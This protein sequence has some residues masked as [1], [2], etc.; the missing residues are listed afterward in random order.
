VAV[1]F[2]FT[3][4]FE[5][6]LLG[7]ADILLMPSLYEPCGITQMRAQL[8]G[9]LP[10]ARRVGGLTDTI[11]DR[12]T[13]FL[14]DEYEPEALR[15]ALHA[16]LTIY[17]DPGAWRDHMRQAMTRDF[18]WAGSVARYHDVYR[19]AIRHRAGRPPPP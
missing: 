8:Y 9:T 3:E 10:V 14:F 5:H 16:A 19:R 13:G 2:D 12:V 4:E 1:R 18:G 17:A 7:G 15:Q 11:V 6:R